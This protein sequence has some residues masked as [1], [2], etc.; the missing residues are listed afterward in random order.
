[1]CNQ[2]TPSNSNSNNPNILGVIGRARD[3]LRSNVSSSL[4]NCMA[5]QPKQRRFSPHQYASSKP[6]KRP[7]QKTLEIAVISFMDPKE[8]SDE[9][10]PPNILPNYALGN[11]N[12]L[13]TGFVDLFTNDKEDDIR[14]KIVEVLDSRVTLTPFDFDFVKV[15][16]KQVTTPAV[17]KEHKWD[18]QQVKSI[19]GQGKLYIRLNKKPGQDNG[20]DLGS[21]EKAF[22]Y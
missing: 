4:G 11:D 21:K 16:R 10:G 2:P 20:N 1:L 19:T 6:S 7:E 3:L 13:F 9:D 14:K 18:Y 12:I 17:K 15:T 5:Q 22:C 8:F